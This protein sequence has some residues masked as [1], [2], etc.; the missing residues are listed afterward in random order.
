M[1]RARGIDRIVH[2]LPHGE[3]IEFNESEVPSIW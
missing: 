2:I 3:A 1:L